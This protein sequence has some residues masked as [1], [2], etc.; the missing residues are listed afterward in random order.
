[1]RLTLLQALLLL[2]LAP[3]TPQGEFQQ[4]DAQQEHQK[5]CS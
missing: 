5:W 4:R 1:M 3:M 2:L